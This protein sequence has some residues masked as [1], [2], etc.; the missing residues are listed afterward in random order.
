MGLGTS[1]WLIIGV[2]NVFG[3]PHLSVLFHKRFSQSVASILDT[4]TYRKEVFFGTKSE[5]Q[6]KI[7]F[8]Y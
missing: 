5:M 4:H 6:Q 8:G 1:I 3:T 2:L 7:R